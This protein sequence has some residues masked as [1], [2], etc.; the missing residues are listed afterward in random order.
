MVEYHNHYAS[1]TLPSLAISQRKLPEEGWSDERIELLLQ[2]L[3]LMDSNNYPG[4]HPTLTPSF[5][6]IKYSLPVNEES[7]S[8]CLSLYI[9]C[10]QG[11]LVL[12]SVRLGWPLALL[13]NA[14]T[15]TYVH[16]LVIAL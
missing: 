6:I 2:E 5:N 8:R 7:R 12:V 4:T 3:A 11:M 16:W 1:I 9:M 13:L 10:V 14:I 15:G